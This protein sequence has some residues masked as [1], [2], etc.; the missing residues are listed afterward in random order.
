M[1]VRRT[2]SP[3]VAGALALAGGAIPLAG[4]ASV[5]AVGQAAYGALIFLGAGGAIAALWLTRNAGVWL[6]GLSAV[7]L[8]LAL[9]AVLVMYL[10]PLA[11]AGV[12]L[13]PGRWLAG[14]CEFPPY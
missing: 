12:C 5:G 9:V 10:Q 14:R 11:E 1:A 3:T 7:P 13:P 6:T 4:A 2:R 8:V